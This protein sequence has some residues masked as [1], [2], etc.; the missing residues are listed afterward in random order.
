M[1]ERLSL[2][3]RLAA[4]CRVEA[5]L[6]L[7]RAEVGLLDAGLAD[8]ISAACAE[9][10]TGAAALLREGWQAGSP[11]IPLLAVL[12]ARLGA[13]AAAELHRGATSQDIVDTA[14]MLLT[15][16]ALAEL[17]DGADRIRRRLR[18]LAEAHRDTPT[19]A[20]TF[21]QH[22]GT[23]TLGARAAAWLTAWGRH[24][25]ALPATA[26]GL[27][28]QLGGPVG[29]GEGFDGRGSEVTAVLAR[30]LGLAVPV[31][32][33]HGDR[34]VS[35]DLAARVSLLVATAASIATDL[36]LL[37]QP[38]IAEVRMRPGRSSSIAGKHNP[39]DAVHAIAAADVA[40]SV[41]A[42]LLAPRAP[43]LERAAGAWHAEWFA[44]PVMFQAAAASLEALAAA[45]GSLEVD[46]E[47]MATNLGGAPDA[48]A[49][50]A[51]ADT[52]DRALAADEA[53]TKT[54]PG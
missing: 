33:W 24:V 2:A 44:L 23:T 1:D 28:V 47:R 12:R 34:S 49:L 5:E 50:D 30:R 43:E 14:A 35:A 9:P 32:P 10:I 53:L 3:A 8:E 7:A 27:P 46:A 25:A 17:G 31:L 20:R 6:A 26:V 13:D 54:A 45:L 21:L 29:I 16:D 22:A 41:A 36:V 48:D 18:A 4:M 11:V 39:I 52:V 42:G 37:A 40:G 19:A 38:E 15:R 51:A